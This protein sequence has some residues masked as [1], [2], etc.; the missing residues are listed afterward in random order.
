MERDADEQER[1]AIPS[2]EAINAGA[3]VG[4]ETL[5]LSNEFTHRHADCVKAWVKRR[6]RRAEG[7]SAT[8][9]DSRTVAHALRAR[10]RRV[11]QDEDMVPGRTRRYV[12]VSALAVFAA[13]LTSC[14]DAGAADSRTPGMPTGIPATGMD[15]EPVVHLQSDGSVAVV[16]W[17]SSSCPAT[18]TTFDNDGDSLVVVFSTSSQGVC[19]ADIAATTHTFSADRVGD[20]VPLEATISFPEFDETHVVQITRP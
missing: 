9:R 2:I 16:T 6:F 5:A 8:G 1:R 13:V 18:A 19:T 3:D 12:A 10:G 20:A 17:G 15:F 4:A 7:D 11:R 14:S